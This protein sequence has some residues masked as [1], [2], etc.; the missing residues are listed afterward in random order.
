MTTA[1]S[2]KT[3]IKCDAFAIFLSGSNWFVTKCAMA[4]LEAMT[5]CV[6]AVAGKVLIFMKA[7]VRHG[8]RG[9]GFT[10]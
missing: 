7:S 5:Q 9:T 10:S 2:Q 3:N 8:L 1:C 4:G 6:Q